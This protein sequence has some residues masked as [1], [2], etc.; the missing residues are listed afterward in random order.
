MFKMDEDLQ[1][2]I[3]ELSEIYDKDSEDSFISLYVNNKDDEKFIKKRVND[4]ITV[5]K[6]EELENF[7]KTI[8]KVEDAIKKHGVAKSVA[9]FASEKN[10]FLKVIELP[11]DVDNQLIVDSSP[12]LRPLIRI[13]DEWESF[14]LLLMNTHFAKIFKVEMGE[15]GDSKK[16]SKDIMNKH[17]K[18]GWSQA[19]FNRLRKGAIDHFYKE[20]IDEL[21]DKEHEHIII[22][23]PGQAKI[24]FQKM[25]PQ[26][27]Q[28]K[29]VN[30]LDIDIDDQDDLLKKSL[31]IISE[32]ENKRSEEA[33]KLLKQEILKEGLGVYGVEETLQAAKN[34]QIELLIV[35]KDHR[36]PGWI[37]E[38]CQLVKPGYKDKCPYCN[39]ETSK[40]DMIEE[41]IEFAERTDAKIE[42]TSDEEIGKLGHV[43]AILRYK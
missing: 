21:Q 26:H 5:L 11:I 22:A 25:L 33:T 8:E 1:D 20:I 39:N 14:T 31:M 24:H 10:S 30:V 42:F 23:G 16:I 28:E 40:V 7:E 17:K 27:L 36:I 13:M 32:D 35:E 6:N 34:G 43:G 15:V 37:C 18:G 9:V 29:I 3:R 19:R 2:T 12:Y 41:I 38:N 4:C